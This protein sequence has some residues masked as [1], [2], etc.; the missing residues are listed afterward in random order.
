MSIAGLAA[1]EDNHPMLTAP[2]VCQA[3]RLGLI[4]LV[5]V[6]GACDRN[7]VPAQ[8]VDGAGPHKDIGQHLD[9]GGPDSRSD[10]PVA[11]S[12]GNPLERAL[13]ACTITAS[14]AMG[15]STVGIAWPL[16]SP[17]AC[18]DAL[19]RQGWYKDGLGNTTDPALV[20]RL[21]DC[22]TS[23]DC[24]KVISCF[25]GNWIS[26][27]RCREGGTC[28]GNKLVT[29]ATSVPYFDCSSIGSTCM[30]LY[31]GAQRACCNEKPCKGTN[32]VTCQGKKG[33]YCHPWGAYIAFDCGL[34]NRICST[35]AAA[36][37][38]GTGATCSRSKTPTSCKG[39]M[40]SFCS[41]GRLASVNCGQNPYRSKCAAGSLYQACIP[42]GTECD[43]TQYIGACSGDGLKVC[44]DGRLEM[45]DC[46]KLGFDA[47]D[48]PA[49]ATARCINLP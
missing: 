14:C 47:C 24:N 4:I 8:Q 20:K 9:R 19:G 44:L 18:L 7:P 34:T 10:G 6:L 13:K 43:P 29:S 45:V 33:S 46:K 49:G 26:L 25:G 31:S 17:G 21:F 16:F 48:L 3:A 23:A 11:D 22:A 37:C 28:S 42:S 38:Q 40:A 1:Q 15:K 39:A 35:D 12:G 2:H 5:T 32:K 36:F 27:S 30:D 41:G